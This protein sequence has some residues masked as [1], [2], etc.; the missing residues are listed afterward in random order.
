MNVSHK[1]WL[2]VKP[3]LTTTVFTELQITELWGLE[4]TSRDHWIQSACQSRLPR[5]GC[6][7]RCSGASWISP[8]KETPQFLW[9]ACSSA[10]S[11][12]LWRSSYSCLCRTYYAPVCG[13]LPL[14]YPH[15][16]LK[17][18]WPCPLASHT[19]DI[20]GLYR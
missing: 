10:L 3:I 15:I 6:N 12:S 4:E 1:S 2:F 8:E 17:R 20:Y 14:S 16:L 13:C 5:A 11:P 18:A 19:L 7:G 9:A